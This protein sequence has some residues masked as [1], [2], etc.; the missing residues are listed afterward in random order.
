MGKLPARQEPARTS[1]LPLRRFLPRP[2]PPRSDSPAA[3]AARRQSDFGVHMSD[4][5]RCLTLMTLAF[6]RRCPRR[7]WPEQVSRA[8]FGAEAVVTDPR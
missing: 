7:T 2:I 6:Q 4:A 5:D 8:R 3:V 1:G